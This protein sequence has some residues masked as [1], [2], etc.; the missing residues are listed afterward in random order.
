MKKYNFILSFISTIHFQ[1]S[2]ENCHISLSLVFFFFLFR[3]V[4]NTI[5]FLQFQNNIFKKF[6]NVVR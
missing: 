2:E 4:Y 1:L 5:I 3:T 6:Y